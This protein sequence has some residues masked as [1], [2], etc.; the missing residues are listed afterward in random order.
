MIREIERISRDIINTF[1]AKEGINH[2]N[3]PNLPSRQSIIDLITILESIIFPGFQEHEVLEEEYLSFNIGG[4]LLKAGQHLICEI[5]KSLN[6]RNNPCTEESESGSHDSE[7][8]ELAFK[9]LSKLPTIREM[10]VKD[11]NAALEG[12]PAAKSREEVILSY[13]GLEA[14]TVHRMAHELYLMDVPLIPRMMNEHIHRKTGIDIHPGASIDESFFIDH[15]TGV[16]I[17]ETTCIGKNC[18]VYQGVTLGALSVKKEEA[19]VKRH[20]TLEDNVTIYSG[21]TILGGGTIIGSNTVIGGNLWITSSIAAD[22]LVYNRPVEYVLK[23]RYAH[24]DK[25]S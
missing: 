1:R 9:F 5:G 23:N 21:A 10:A 20:P 4:K 2:L 13:P 24:Q 8:S 17:G 18:K 7:A 12:D 25:K 11:V 15:G 3:G 6:C 14:I 19:N 22:S 16:V